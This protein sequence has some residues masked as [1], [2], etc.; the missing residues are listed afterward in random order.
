MYERIN[1]GFVAL[2]TEWRLTYMNSHATELLGREREQL[3]GK[4]LSE[5]FPGVR[6]TEF[7]DA[8]TDVVAEQ[9]VIAV[10]EQVDLID[11]WIEARIFPDVDGLSIYFREITGR[12]ERERSLE[13]SR[14]RYRALVDAAPAAILVTDAESGDIVEANRAAE[15]LLGRSADDLTGENHSAIHPAEDKKLYDSLFRERVDSGSGLVNRHADGS[16]IYVE[17]AAGD[18]IPVEITSQV[19]ELEDERLIQS[20]IRDVVKRS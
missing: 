20:V 11:A 12:K 18:R 9:E 8:A 4:E 3:L 14:K 19:I 15:E 6:E 10:E 2:D 7:Y 13:R 1:D 5:V 16:Q 17:T